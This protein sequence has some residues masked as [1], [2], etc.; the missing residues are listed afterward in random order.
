[1]GGSGSPGAALL[2]VGATGAASADYDLLYVAAA[3]LTL[4]GALA[5]IPVK[6]VR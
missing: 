6:K 4:V 5:I 1:M 3:V 2:T